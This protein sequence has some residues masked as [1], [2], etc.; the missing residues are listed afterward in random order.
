MPWGSYAIQGKVTDRATNELIPGIEVKFVYPPHL[1]FP[2][3][4]SMTD[5]K[6]DFKLS[7]VVFLDSIPLIATDIDGEKNGLYR[8][9]TIYVDYSKAQHIG[10]GDG[11]FIGKLVATADFKLEAVEPDE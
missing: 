6:G 10:G 8:S 2:P 5:N 1:S 9:D 7:N 3:S 4:E 11:W